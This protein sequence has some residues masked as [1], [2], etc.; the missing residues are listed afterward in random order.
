MLEEGCRSIQLTSFERSSQRVDL[1]V[2]PVVG[3]YARIHHFVADEGPD[4]PR[5]PIPNLPACRALGITGRAELEAVAYQNAGCNWRCWYCFVPFEDLTARRG[6][7]VLVSEMVDGVEAMRNPDRP[8]MVDLTGGQPDLVPEWPV[9]FLE[10]LDNRGIDDV[11]VWSDDNLSIDYFWRYLTPEQIAFLGQHRMYGRVGCLKGYDGRS[12]AFNTKARSELF[13]RQL[14]LIARF[15]KQT[16]V[17]LYLYATFT[18]PTTEGIGPAMRTLAR[19]LGDISP[20]LLQRLVPLKVAEWGP[21]TARLDDERRTAV[22]NQF[23]A[24]EAWRESLDDLGVAGRSDE[25]ETVDD[26]PALLR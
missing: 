16:S 7:M 6:D 9:W 18:T 3:G 23:A 20:S 21:V 12:F 19:R 13:E 11:Y 26:V 10:E 4:W 1:S 14:D 22:R 25:W 8:M 17:D 24:L 2:P 15:V 5:N